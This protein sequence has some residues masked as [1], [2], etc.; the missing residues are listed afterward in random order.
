MR[1]ARGGIRPLRPHASAALLF[2]VLTIVLTFPLALRMSDHV[3]DA[4]DPLLNT[5]ILAWDVE[6]LAGGNFRHFFDANI[7]FPHRR[8][9]AYSEHLFPQALLAA[10]PLLASGNP[11]LAYNVVFLCAF[12]TSALGM[13]VLAYRLTASRTASAVA[14]VI[15]AFSPFMFDHLSH[16]QVLSAGGIPLTYFFLVR[17]FD[18]ERWRDALLT[19]VCFVIQA[20]ANGY[21]ALFLALFLALTVLYHAVS[22]R[23]LLD[24][25][26]LLKLAAMAA[27][28]AVLTGPFFYQYLELKTEMGLEREI[29]ASA[30]LVSYAAV[31][32]FN[33]LYG[34][35]KL[36]ENETRLFPGI[37][38]LALAG[39]GIAS[40]R[41]KRR[42]SYWLRLFVMTLL[43][44]F[45]LSLGEKGPFRIVH[46]HVPGFDAIR[47]VARVHVF[48]L[49]SLAV[50]AAFGARRV[51]AAAADWKRSAAGALAVVLIT[52]EYL[53]I[54]LPLE[55]IPVGDEIPA[56]YKWLA[57]QEGGPPVLELPL[58][59][60]YRPGCE[61]VYYST[62]H[63][64][65]IVNGF[66]GFIPPLYGELVRRWNEEPP[67]QTV[68]DAVALGVRYLVAHKGQM[69]AE[70]SAGLRAALV[71]RARWV[72]VFSA[73]EVWELPAAGA[74][75]AVRGPARGTSLPR[76]RWRVASSEPQPADRAVDGDLSTRWHSEGPQR[77]GVWLEVD[78]GEVQP[79]SGLSLA[80]AASPLDYP[81]GYEVG[82]SVDGRSWT[83]VRRDV[84]DR[85][86]IPAFLDP[87]RLAVD[88][89]FPRSEARFVRVL[90]TR[91][92]PVYYWSIYEIEI[93]R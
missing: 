90:C 77:P 89:G 13:Y 47:A 78:L 21:F 12:F 54:P 60:Q 88:I 71:G 34:R 30:R 56:V 65:P 75:R 52:A 24:R 58:R 19:A 80:L 14:G 26:F 82:L 79:V 25:A 51:L 9:L 40:L 91:G 22:A 86:P 6:Q 29:H 39:V 87:R 45:V 32:E 83:P 10:G 8:T 18:R 68:D 31:P 84:L 42:E 28:V 49:L 4:G 67:E 11:I 50:A 93:R 3:R 23:K 59:P 92:D 73:D 27:V 53:S 64:K 72:G 16:L 70:E 33:L 43:L 38:P 85:L 74:E 44:A 37:V 1:P 36:G 5:W 20:L 35:W 66:S 41:R 81:R 69:S 63:W 46:A 48:T 76:G 57:R 55:K 7:F 61:R 15:Y 62:Y 2:A 17:F